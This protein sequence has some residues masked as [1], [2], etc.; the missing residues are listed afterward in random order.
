M[1]SPII[2]LHS[3]A[4]Q[5]CR[6]QIPRV[7]HLLHGSDSVESVIY[8]ILQV[9]PSFINPDLLLSEVNFIGISTNCTPVRFTMG[10]QITLVGHNEHVIFPF[11]ICIVKTVCLFRFRP[12]PLRTSQCRN[13]LTVSNSH[14]RKSCNDLSA[15]WFPNGKWSSEASYFDQMDLVCIPNPKIG[16][17]SAHSLINYMEN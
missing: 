4:P 13:L 2:A 12:G 11:A 9:A 6:T 15:Y 17:G 16:G 1:T 3:R 10:Y 14:S 7:C 8:P 5:C